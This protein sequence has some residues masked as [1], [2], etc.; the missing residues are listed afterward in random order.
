MDLWP[1]EEWS[2]KSLSEAWSV[3]DVSAHMLVIPTMSKGQVF[4]AFAGSGF[5]LD[6]MNTKLVKKLT[7]AMSPE[8]IV[9]ATRSSAG[10][11][12][13]PPGLNLP[14]AFT[15]LV[16]HANDVAEVV[17]RPVNF[18][19]ADYVACLNHLKGVQA[20][21][22]TKKRIEGLTLR[23]TDTD[24]ATG[25]GAKVEGSAKDLLLA[26]ASRPIAFARLTGDGVTTLAS[27]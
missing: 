13:T 22:G 17:G 15:E 9:A 20:V 27:R 1:A 21:F 24:W 14:G 18:E 16:V 8:E 6:K 19:T 4:R 26:M 7:A 10:S 3:K 5:N 11:K 23:A 12:S 25:G 2:A